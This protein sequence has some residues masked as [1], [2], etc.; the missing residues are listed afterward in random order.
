MNWRNPAVNRDSRDVPKCRGGSGAFRNTRLQNAMRSACGNEPAAGTVIALVQIVRG[1]G[2]MVPIATVCTA[3]SRSTATGPTPEGT[4]EVTVDARIA[5][6]EQD[7]E[8]QQTFDESLEAPWL[9][10]P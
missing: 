8:V 1:G 6:A 10:A 9:P 5:V 7:I 2:S 4:P 3:S